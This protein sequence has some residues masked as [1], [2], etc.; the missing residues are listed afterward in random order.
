[1]P[2]VLSSVHTVMSSTENSDVHPSTA[3]NS[4]TKIS[5]SNTDLVRSHQTETH[6]S[7]SIN[8]STKS[9]N[10]SNSR[11]L[12]NKSND[13]SD[14]NSPN[15]LERKHKLPYSSR[16]KKFHRHFYQVDADEDV[17]NCK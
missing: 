13:L 14:T 3:R 11:K 6:L 9:S 5:T 10:T 15:L 17:I 2:T 12:S 8:A 4:Y 1:M 16:Q 7:E